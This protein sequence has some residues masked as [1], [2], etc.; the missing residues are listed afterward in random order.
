MTDRAC[1]GEAASLAWSY[2]GGLPRY[3]ENELRAYL[4]CGTCRRA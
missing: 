3:V 4:K 2:D 1:L